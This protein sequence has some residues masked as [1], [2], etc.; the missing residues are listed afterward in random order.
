MSPRSLSR[1]PSQPWKPYLSWEP[2]YLSPVLLPRQMP[3]A[4]PAEF[5][6]RCYSTT[7]CH[8]CG[9]GD[10]FSSRWSVSRGRIRTRV[11]SVSVAAGLRSPCRLDRCDGC[12]ALSS[13]E[14]NNPPVEPAGLALSSN[15]GFPRL[16]EGTTERWTTKRTGLDS[17]YRASFT[18]I[19]VN[20]LFVVPAPR[21]HVWCRSAFTA[22]SSV[23]HRGTG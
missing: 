16:L 14:P 2:A 19:F 4:C 23:T 6:V 13:N 15:D 21:K 10:A 20:H 11:A 17:W 7:C 3:P 8:H 5:H 12:I 1:H 18:H 22:F 9:R